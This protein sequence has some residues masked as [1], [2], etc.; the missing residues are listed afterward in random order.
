MFGGMR[1]PAALVVVEAAVVEVDVIVL[2]CL[3][4]EVV[5]VLVVL[6]EVSGRIQVSR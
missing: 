6:V 2:V 3:V 4:V 1:I 5:W